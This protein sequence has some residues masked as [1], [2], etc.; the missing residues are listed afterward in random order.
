LKQ[1]LI[2]CEAFL[3]GRYDEL[4]EEHCFMRGSMK[5]TTS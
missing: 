2:D 1:T 5:E 4:P 3:T